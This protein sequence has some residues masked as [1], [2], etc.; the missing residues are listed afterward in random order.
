MTQ[1]EYNAVMDLSVA[2]TE[3]LVSKAQQLEDKDGAHPSAACLAVLEEWFEEGSVSE[4]T[5]RKFLAELSEAE[6]KWVWDGG[7]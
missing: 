4:L 5:G 1:K 6:R 7:H 3:R 2:R